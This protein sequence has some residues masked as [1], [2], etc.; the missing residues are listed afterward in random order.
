VNAPW[1]AAGILAWVGTVIH[2]V[3]GEKIVFSNTDDRAIPATSGAP[4][5]SAMARSL[6]R[7]TWHLTSAAFAIL[8]TA[9]LVCGVA[10]S[11]DATKGAARV[12]AASF[13]AYAL[14]VVVSAL[15]RGP[16][17]LWRHPAPLMLTL[18]AAL[19]W[20]GISA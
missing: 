17:S 8:G 16:K 3:G 19:V 14:V 10:G 13:S 7:T 20:W 18:T 12:V 2:A 4:G 9:L 5:S 6:A 11:S 1:I 15:S